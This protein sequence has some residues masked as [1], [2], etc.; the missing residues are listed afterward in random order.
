MLKAQIA[1][2]IS[3]KKCTYESSLSEIQK[4]LYKEYN[5]ESTLDEIENELLDIQYD[6][7]SDYVTLVQEDFF[8][9]Y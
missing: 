2:L 4:L 8:Q 3:K 9:G 7:M 1:T 5:V 6:E